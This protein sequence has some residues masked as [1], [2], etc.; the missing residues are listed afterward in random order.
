MQP[1]TKRLGGGQLLRHLVEN[2][3]VLLVTS[4]KSNMCCEGC[5]I[6]LLVKQVSH[7]CKDDSGQE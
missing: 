1:L 4:L 2:N 5:T 3:S 7:P 6:H